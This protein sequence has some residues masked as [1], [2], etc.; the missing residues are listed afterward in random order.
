MGARP[1]PAWIAGVI[2]AGTLLLLH[3]LECRRPLRRSVEPKLRREA[4]NLAV[5]GVS[6]IAVV[7]AERPI[8]MPLAGVIEE[9]GWGLLRLL[10][11]PLGLEIAVALLFMDY[12]FYVWHIFMHRI[13][14]LWRFHL[15]HHVDLDLDA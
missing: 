5:A 13:P 2:G 10:R 3:W 9:R 12:T 15:V 11:L 4:R 1:L 8:V 14:L 6:A 7:L